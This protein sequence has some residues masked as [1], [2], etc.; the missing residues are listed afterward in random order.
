MTFASRCKACIKR[1]NM[2]VLDL[3]AWFGRPYTTVW[4]WVEGDWEPRPGL[5]GQ[6]AE[7][8][9]S[10]LEKLLASKTPLVIPSSLSSSKR[11]EHVRSAYH[12]ANGARV[13]EARTAR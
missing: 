11:A 8:D 6:K 1:G 9:L 10:L 2:T 4:R 5:D 12:A 13:P 3:A 7:A